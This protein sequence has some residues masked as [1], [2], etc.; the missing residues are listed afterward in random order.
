MVKFD[1]SVNHRGHFVL[2]IT[3]RRYRASRL[4]RHLHRLF[5]HLFMILI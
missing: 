5:M 3:F 4:R 2:Y 1:A